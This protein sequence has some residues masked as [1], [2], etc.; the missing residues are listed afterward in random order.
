MR[1]GQGQRAPA[2]S[3][4]HEPGLLGQLGDAVSAIDAAPDIGAVAA[5]QTQFLDKTPPAKP[6]VSSPGGIACAPDCREEV[7][8]GS[9]FTL[10]ATPGINSVFTGWGVGCTGTGPCTITVNQAFTVV[11]AGFRGAP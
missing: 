10:V 11:I 1:A 6:V 3:A 8:C 2:R 5:A 7:V 9:T 4:E